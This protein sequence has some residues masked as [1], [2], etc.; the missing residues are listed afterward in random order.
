MIHLLLEQ[1]RKIAKKSTWI[2]TEI[3]M[4][5]KVAREQWEEGEWWEN[6]FVES[7]WYEI[8]E[9]SYLYS[10]GEGTNKEKKYLKELINIPFSLF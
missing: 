3:L 10:R 1:S 2:F 7:E 5:F 8:E 9:G 6:F 4:L